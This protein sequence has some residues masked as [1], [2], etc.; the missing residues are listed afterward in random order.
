ME[1]G[2][3]PLLTSS[4]TNENQEMG[5]LVALSNIYGVGLKTLRTLHEQFGRLSSVWEGSE[6]E[7]LSRLGTSHLP[8]LPSILREIRINKKEL[9][10]AA[11]AQLD[12]FDKR[13]ISIIPRSDPRF[14]SRLNEIP[15][16]PTGCLLRVM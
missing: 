4:A 14:L 6:D 9:V 16:L 10:Q 12:A 7:L 1:S 5:S 8:R 2:Q 13:N 11:K 15:T 3:L